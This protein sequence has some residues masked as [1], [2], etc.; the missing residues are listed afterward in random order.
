MWESQLK[1]TRLCRNGD[2]DLVGKVEAATPLPMLLLQEDLYHRAQLGALNGI[3][4]AVVGHVHA[5]EVL[6]FRRE[7][8][9]LRLGAA[10][11]AKPVEQW[12]TSSFGVAIV[13][14]SKR[15]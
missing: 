6:P 7:Q 9:L 5:H 11:V 8:T 3:E 15:L 2:A 10:M 12:A 13:S 14:F 1:Q 4:H